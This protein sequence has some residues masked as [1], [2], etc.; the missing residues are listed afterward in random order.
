MNTRKFLATTAAAA[1]AATAAY[2][3]TVAPFGQTGVPLR[4]TEPLPFGPLPGGR[5]PDPHLESLKK[6]QSFVRA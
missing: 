1:T 4:P 6:T 3:G 2:A 5:Y